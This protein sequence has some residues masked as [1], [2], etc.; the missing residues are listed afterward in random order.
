MIIFTY[1]T[2]RSTHPKALFLLFLTEMWERF[3]YYGM[4]ALLMLYMVHQ[5]QYADAKAN[6]I[7][8]T[9]TALVYLMPLFGG[10]AA[11][12]V[13]GYRRAITLG[14]ILMAIGHFI[15]AIPAEWSFFAG[16]AFLISGNGFFKPNIS[17]MVG[18]L[19]PDGD[20]RTD[21]AFSIFYMGINVGA[22]LGGLLC[23][24]I[25]EKGSDYFTFMTKATSWHFGFGLAGIFMVLGLINFQITQHVLGDIGLKPVKEKHPDNKGIRI[26][27]VYIYI[28]ALL[29]VPLFILLFR[30]Y[31]VMQYIMFPVCLMALMYCIL[32]A[33]DPDQHIQSK[34]LYQFGIFYLLF[35][36]L[37]LYEPFTGL[38]HRITVHFNA[39]FLSGLD[40]TLAGTTISPILFTIKSYPISLFIVLIAVMVIFMIVKA[41]QFATN[42]KESGGKQIAAVVLVT[43]SVL[44]WAFYEQGG[45]SLNLFADRNVELHGMGAAAL[46]NNIN[47]TMIILLSGLFASLWL[48]LAKRNKEPSTPTKF[49]VAFLQLG[50]AFLIFVTGAKFVGSSGRESLSF[51]VL[52]Y[53]L[54]TTGELCLSPI[55]LSMITKLAPQRFTGMMMGFWFIASAMGQYLA[56]VIGTF[57][58][59]PS[60][61]GAT[62]VTVFQS[63]EIYSGVFMKIFY[64]SI[65]VGIALLLLVPVLKHWSQ[66]KPK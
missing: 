41:A 34:S 49:G 18:R 16:M 31:T 20:P 42:N 14:A 13:M 43:F 33:E 45:G 37:F 8:G 58:A 61:K 48:A 11:D 4:R 15:L 57:M 1:L 62:T 9:Y 3:S 36:A 26:T 38:L 60:E 35:L 5:L 63:L 6:L 51:F 56:G 2:N 27:P 44:F 19:Y 25:G 40:K 28:A 21:G 46:N 47:P 7:Y 55:G 29:I 39:T 32:I 30:H 54:M 64:V 23:G 65:G 12:R 52:G 66:E 22:A 10:M 59:V 24:F 50:F 17:T 53:L